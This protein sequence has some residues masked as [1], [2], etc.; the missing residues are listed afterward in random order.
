[1]AKA[2]T[3][4][5]A[6][7]VHTEHGKGSTTVTVACKFPCGV[8][9]Q[10]DYE[11]PFYEETRDGRIKRIRYDKRGPTYTVRGPAE[12]NGQTPKGYRRPI[13]E[14]GFALTHN[15]PRDFWDEW[16]RQ[17][18]DTKL[19][20]SG[21]IFACPKPDDTHGL[22]RDGEHL[23]SGLEPINPDGDPRKPK[24]LNPMVGSVETAERA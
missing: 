22:A 20:T 19:V 12:P 11:T 5:Q 16:F 6:P 15:I 4:I 18:K 1:M 10:L 7:S 14:G 8:V 17:N 24:S 9:L 13:T 23:R 21:L 2:A 3:A